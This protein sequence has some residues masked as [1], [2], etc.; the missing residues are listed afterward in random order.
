LSENNTTRKCAWECSQAHISIICF[1]HSMKLAVST[2]RKICVER[3][4]L[5]FE[6]IYHPFKLCGV[7]IQPKAKKIKTFCVLHIYM[8]NLPSPLAYFS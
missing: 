6:E 5:A 4:N 7:I 3:V 8:E 2:E 1:V